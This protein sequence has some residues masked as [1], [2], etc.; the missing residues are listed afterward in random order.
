M[1]LPLAAERATSTV[2][3]ITPTYLSEQPSDPACMMCAMNC[4]TTGAV[5]EPP[6]TALKSLPPIAIRTCERSYIQIE[7][8][9][10]IGSISH[11]V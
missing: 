7:P 10:R 2:A 6:V 8:S 5:S 11:L 1:R 4:L 9:N 3:A